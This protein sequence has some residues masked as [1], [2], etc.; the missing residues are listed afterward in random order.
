MTCHNM[1]HGF[2]DLSGSGMA[3]GDVCL[4]QHGRPGKL[5]HACTC[6]L[7][8]RS[9]RSSGIGGFILLLGLNGR[10]VSWP[11]PNTSSQLCRFQQAVVFL[12]GGQQLLDSVV[13]STTTLSMWHVV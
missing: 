8:L 5:W 13:L 3:A 11:A 1:L 7:M 12:W 10:A 2:L 9:M 4:V 6:L